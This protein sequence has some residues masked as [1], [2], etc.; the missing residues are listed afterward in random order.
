MLAQ[1]VEDS[2]ADALTLSV[3]TTL[4]PAAELRFHLT[5]FISQAFAYSGEGYE[6]IQI[7]PEDAERWGVFAAVPA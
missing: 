5:A 6:K 4:L 7:Q 2:G 1:M 3:D